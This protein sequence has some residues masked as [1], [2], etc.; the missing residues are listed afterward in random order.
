VQQEL[1]CPGCGRD[2][3]V[4][5]PADAR[6]EIERSQTPDYRPMVTI[7]IG[8]VDIHHC[9]MCPDGTWR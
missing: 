5:R 4:G 9:Q 2:I 6:V 1:Q 8:R 3:D 7:L